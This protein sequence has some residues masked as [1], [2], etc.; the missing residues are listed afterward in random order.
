[1]NLQEY[2]Y[3]KTSVSSRAEYLSLFLRLEFQ[4]LAAIPVRQYPDW[5]YSAAQIAGQTTGFTPSIECKYRLASATF[6]RHL[7]IGLWKSL[8]GIP[9]KRV[10][11]YSPHHDTQKPHEGPCA[12]GQSARTD[13]HV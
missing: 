3:K 6:F 7:S 13:V 9:E 12:E 1:V 8:A 11:T 4:E 5:H 2:K 10:H